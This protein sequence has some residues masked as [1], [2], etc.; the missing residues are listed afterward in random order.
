METGPL[1]IEITEVVRIEDYK[2]R[3]WSNAEIRMTAKRACHPFINKQ[4]PLGGV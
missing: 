4:V 3:E 1:G 2:K